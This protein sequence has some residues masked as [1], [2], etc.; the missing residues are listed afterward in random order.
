MEIAPDQEKGSDQPLLEQKQ[1]KGV[2]AMHSVF[3]ATGHLTKVRVQAIDSIDKPIDTK[4]STIELQA[5][6][7]SGILLL[8]LCTCCALWLIGSYA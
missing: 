3:Y 5:K 4:P 8:S 1:P 2:H 7:C 6:I